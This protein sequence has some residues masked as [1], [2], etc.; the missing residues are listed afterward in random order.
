MFPIGSVIVVFIV[1]LLIQQYVVEPLLTQS[2]ELSYS[3][4]KTD[5]R[6]GKVTSVSV[7]TD[8]IT[9]KLSDGKDFYTQGY[10]P[11]CAGQA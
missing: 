11:P 5:L 7:S 3:D 8:R 4:F 6:A 10:I 1:L 2:T 9:G